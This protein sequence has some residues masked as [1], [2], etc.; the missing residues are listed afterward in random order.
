MLPSIR[1][2]AFRPQRG[3]GVAENVNSLYAA[4][5]LA[6][7]GGAGKEKMEDTGG[8]V[9]DRADHEIQNSVGKEIKPRGS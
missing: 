6:T 3:A 7:L 4:L 1:R 8:N 9:Q 5:E 2:H